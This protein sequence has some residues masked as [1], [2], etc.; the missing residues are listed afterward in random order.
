MLEFWLEFKLDI[1]FVFSQILRLVPTAQRTCRKPIVHSA[2]LLKHNNTAKTSQCLFN[3]I[4]LLRTTRNTT[5]N[6]S[7]F[8]IYS[9]VHRPILYKYCKFTV[10]QRRRFMILR[11]IRNVAKIR[12]FVLGAAG[13]AGVSAKLVSFNSFFDY[14]LGRD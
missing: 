14:H 6:Y 12:Y 1:F 3:Q 7:S 9:N 11:V 2:R 5:R 8:S 4:N 10:Q 13:T